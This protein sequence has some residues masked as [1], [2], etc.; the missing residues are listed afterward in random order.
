VTSRCR[1]LRM[2]QGLDGRAGAGLL[3]DI[4]EVGPGGNFLA[5]PATRTAVRSGEFYEPAL[6]SRAHCDAWHALGKPRMYERARDRA[7]A[8]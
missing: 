8:R 1:V 4:A 2:G 7:L 3:D 5:M 6:I